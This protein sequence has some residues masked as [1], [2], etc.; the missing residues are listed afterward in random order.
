[1][2]KH[3]TVKKS[4]PAPNPEWE[5][6]FPKRFVFGDGDT[7]EITDVTLPAGRTQDFPEEPRP[8]GP[9]HYPDV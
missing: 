4:G 7:L 1:M 6:A 9:R 8:H 5:S 2:K 3:F